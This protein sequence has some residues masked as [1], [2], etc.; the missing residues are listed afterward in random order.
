MRA[1]LSFTATNAGERIRK[2]YRG[3]AGFKDVSEE[4]A[5]PGA[6]GRPT[7]P[8]EFPVPSAQAPMPSW[9]SELPSGSSCPPSSQA[10]GPSRPPGV[11]SGRSC[12]PVRPD[13]QAVSAIRA[14]FGEVMPPVRQ[15]IK[16][17]T[18]IRA[19]FRE[20]MPP[21]LSAFRTSSWKFC[22][23][24]CQASRPSWPAGLSSGS[25]C[26]LP[27]QASRPSWP[28]GQPSGSSCPPRQARL[29]GSHGHQ[30]CLQGA[31]APCPA[32]LPGRRGHQGCIQG[33]PAPP[34]SQASRQ[35]WPP[36][37]HSGSSCPHVRAGFQAVVAIRAAFRELRRHIR[38]GFQAV[39]AIRAAF[40]EILPPRQGQASRQSRASDCLREFC[41]H[42]RPGFQAVKGI[43]TAS[44][45]SAPTS[46]PGFLAVKGIG[47]P[48]GVLPPRQARHPGRHGHRTASGS[49]VPTQ[50]FQAV[51]GIRTASGSSAPTS[52]QASRPSWPS[53]LPLGV[54]APCQARL[55]GSRGQGLPSGSSVPTSDQASRQSW[56]RAAFREFRPPVRPGF[57]AVMAIRNAFRE[58]LPT[59]RA[60]FHVRAGSF[61]VRASPYPNL[62]GS[63][64]FAP[65][66]SQ[67]AL[68]P[69]LK[70]LP[71]ELAP[72]PRSI[73]AHP[74]LFAFPFSPLR[75]T[76]PSVPSDRTLE[77]RFSPKLTRPT[78][79]VSSPGPRSP[80]LM[81]R[82]GCRGHPCRVIRSREHAI[83]RVSDYA[84]D[85]LLNDGVGNVP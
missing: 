41:P 46:G 73:S 52:G 55:P 77:L 54:P 12:H 56:P 78:S 39:V 59:V 69:P 68:R 48:Q 79:A 23:L 1:D 19:T 60:G 45:S 17:V 29:P 27:G 61:L 49:S 26:P 31:P 36:G 81:P 80:C 53:G 47:L 42:F 82:S 32:R 37:L 11:P 28:S 6:P 25:S 70:T 57:Q 7:D 63:R 34:S 84:G 66:N 2:E 62:R 83:C 44:G 50:G 30:G 13:L 10:S 33:V 51:K 64:R 14:A 35:S 58:H 71:A 9:H 16:A 4:R 67:G 74:A 18:A 5:S 21:V 15:G 76:S 85:A 72:G 40:R 20:F 22:P 75:L 38:P 24:S 65:R 43:R 8:R 3:F